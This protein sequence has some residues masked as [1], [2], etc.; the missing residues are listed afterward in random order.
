MTSVVVDSGRCKSSISFCPFGKLTHTVASPSSSCIWS[1]IDSEAWNA[2]LP[3]ISALREY[4]KKA[5]SDA[6]FPQGRVISGENAHIPP[7]E[8]NGELLGESA[9]LT[10]DQLVKH[11]WNKGEAR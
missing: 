10:V 6:V 7:L 1:Y 8:L 4:P 5:S 2:K 3:E 11:E 9:N